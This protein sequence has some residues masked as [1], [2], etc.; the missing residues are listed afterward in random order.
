[1]GDLAVLH[2]SPYS[3]KLILISKVLTFYFE[4]FLV[5]IRQSSSSGPTNGFFFDFVQSP[6]RES[7]APCA[8]KEFMMAL[9]VTSAGTAREKLLWAFRYEKSTLV[10][11]FSSFVC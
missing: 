1:M 5:K 3:C 10:G 2:T 9:D 6:K 8:A 7:L 11:S 4:S